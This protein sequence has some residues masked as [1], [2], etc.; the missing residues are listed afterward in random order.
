MSV[1]TVKCFA[2]LHK[3]LKERKNMLATVESGFTRNEIYGTTRLGVD[4]AG[5]PDLQEDTFPVEESG[6]ERLVEQQHQKMDRKLQKRQQ[7]MNMNSRH[8]KAANKA[9]IDHMAEVLS[10]RKIQKI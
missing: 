9:S 6:I 5:L 1:D 8:E 7:L 3:A 2:K 4:P 10:D